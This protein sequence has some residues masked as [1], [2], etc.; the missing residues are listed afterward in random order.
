MLSTLV[1]ALLASAPAHPSGLGSD[2]S[3]SPTGGSAAVSVRHVAERSGTLYADGSLSLAW[4]A[5]GR[6]FVATINGEIVPGL[7]TYQSRQ[8]LPAFVGVALDGTVVLSGTVEPTGNAAWRVDIQAAGA[9][10]IRG[11]VIE[12]APGE[13][14]MAARQCDCAD[15]IGLSCKTI[16][17]DAGSSCSSSTS[18]CKW[19]NVAVVSIVVEDVR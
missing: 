7:V 10:P 4:D 15:G 18:T 8:G 6:E 5:I 19:K 2:P 9:P 12:V 3:L 11:E 13:L 17:C 1:F 14:V 16:D